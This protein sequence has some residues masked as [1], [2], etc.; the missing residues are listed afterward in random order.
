MTLAAEYRKALANYNPGA[1]TR[2]MTS[3]A[4]QLAAGSLSGPDTPWTSQMGPGQPLTPSPLD[5]T[6]RGIAIPRRWQYPVGTNLTVT[7]GSTKLVDFKTL[8][9]LSKVYDIAR[10]CIELRRQEI[11]Q[12]RW[13]ITSRD[14]KVTIESDR[15]RSL[16]GFFEYPDRINGR[17]WDGWVKTLLEEVLV[18]DALA[19]YPHPT[20]LPGRG[21]VGSDL[22]ALEILDGSTIK[23]LLDHRGARPMPPQ[24]AYQQVL[25][26]MPRSEMLA[27][28]AAQD[29]AGAP[30]ADPDV[31]LKPYFSG[32]ELYYEIYSPSSD[33]PYGF[34]NLEQII[35]NVNLALKRQQY[36]TSYFT[37]GTVPAGY[38]QVPE[39]WTAPMIREFEEGWNSLLAGDMAW[40]HRIKASPG[41]FN[42]LRPLVGGDAAVV[43]FDE[44]LT[45]ITC[46]GF[47]VTPTE[48][49]LDPKSGLGGT[50]WSEQQENVMYRK[51]L[52]PLA[53]WIEVILNEIL[54]TWL[55]SPDLQFKFVFD[56]IEDALKK[57]QQFQIEFETGQ[58]TAN[59]L[60]GELGLAPSEEPN[61]NKLIVITR[62][63]PTLLADIDALSK[64][65][66]GLN[67]DGSVRP[68]P[69][70]PSVKVPPDP[71]ANPEGTAPAED[72]EETTGSGR[73]MTPPASKLALFEDLQKWRSKAAKALR[74]GRSAAVPFE[75]D[76]IPAQV[77]DEIRDRLK[78][79][80]DPEHVRE[81]FA[82]ASGRLAAERSDAALGR[83]RTW[84]PD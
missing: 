14:P 77:A 78:F 12:M 82:V 9:M 25:Y 29:L 38:I 10:R 8:R 40:K 3:V 17:R 75:S 1:P 37:D 2:D 33:S 79:A 24:P 20:W 71:L 4:Q 23:P 47:D 44:W 76:S 51:S 54:G 31:M 73:P 39:E 48:L 7:P 46:I 28:S 67:R 55:H 32:D 60:R 52:R 18:I 43:A 74:S 84:R 6:Q 68:P 30:L 13:E 22:F 56:E 34:S 65:L 49:G 27:D 16:Y 53:G 11:A 63:G 61:A 41:P 83:W 70:S 26:G 80:S 59:E 72:D 69:S 57:A 58:K 15:L 50:G 36:W 45:K 62:Q 5:P 19:I 66:A 81:T 35:V 21:P 42:A 64:N